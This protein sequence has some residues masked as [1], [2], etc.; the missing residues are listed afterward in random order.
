M[1]HYLEISESLTAVSLDCESNPF[2]ELG[3]ISH[4]FYADLSQNSLIGAN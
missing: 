1:F 3:Q 4:F 2:L